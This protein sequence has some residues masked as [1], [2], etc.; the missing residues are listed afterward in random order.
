MVRT[1][2]IVCISVGLKVCGRLHVI[3][4]AAGLAAGAVELFGAAATG[5]G[6]MGATGAGAAAGAG[7][8]TWPSVGDWEAGSATGGGAAGGATGAAG[9]CARTE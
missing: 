9:A 5:A 6:C 2:L 8:A 3:R 4:S 7:A 1:W